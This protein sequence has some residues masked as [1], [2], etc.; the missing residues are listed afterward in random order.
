[1]IWLSSA[2]LLGLLSGEHRFDWSENHHFA[3]LAQDL[4]AGQ[5]THS[6]PP[7]G[8]CSRQARKEKQ[9]RYHRF[10]DWAHAHKLELAPQLAQSLEIRASVWAMPCRTISC[11][12]DK[13]ASTHRWWI[14]SLGLTTL[15]PD[16][17]RRSSTAWFVSFPPG[18]AL[19][20]LIPLWLGIPMVPDIPLTWA[21]A[22]TIPATLDLALRG[23]WP[24][25]PATWSLFLAAAALFASAMVSIAV[26]GQVWF[27]AQISFAALI[28]G[29]LACWYQPGAHFTCLASICWGMAL[30]CRPSATLGLMSTIC[31]LAWRSKGEDHQNNTPL[32]S[33]FGVL[34]GPLFFLG[35]LAAWNWYRFGSIFEFGHHFL[36]IRW[37]Q[38]IQTLGMFDTSYVLRN[39]LSFIG[40]PPKSF[41]PFQLSIHGLGWLWS[42]PWI[43]WLSLQR[44]NDWGL[45][46]CVALGI[47]PALFYQNTGQL[48]VSYRFALDLLP[49]WVVAAAPRATEQPRR[50]IGLVLYSLLLNLSLAWSWVHT[51]AALFGSQPSNWPF[52]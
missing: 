43:I 50:F 3:H 10:D 38:R 36:E 8:F 32:R 42:T 44:R 20:F 48:Q 41:N 11:Q 7:P 14:P 35:S 31:L 21:L 30:S 40:L 33:R 49:L 16:Q 26:Q 6:T 12:Q 5:W 47:A 15:E 45:F 9:C 28:A 22:G 25:L 1:M 27:L 2:L 17:Y 51:P 46:F 52:S 37:M 18:P 13:V 39:L 23:R 19:W 4:H 29:G 24:S 34:L